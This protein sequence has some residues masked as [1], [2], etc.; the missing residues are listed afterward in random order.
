M[1]MR[2]KSLSQRE[3]FEEEAKRLGGRRT[4]N[5]RRFMQ[6]AKKLGRELEPA[7]VMTGSVEDSAVVW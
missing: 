6:A 2:Q 5:Q 3:Q 4:A 7:G 1:D